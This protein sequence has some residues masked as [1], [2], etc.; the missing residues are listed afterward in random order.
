MNTKRYQCRMQR[1]ERDAKQS[2]TD[3]LLELSKQRKRASE[4][5]LAPLTSAEDDLDESM[6]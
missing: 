3:G 6:T 5:C 2:A 4:G 1:E